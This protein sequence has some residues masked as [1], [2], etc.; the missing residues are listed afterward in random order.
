MPG[1]RCR[2]GWDWRVTAFAH[3]Y[4]QDVVH[5]CN[6]CLEGDDGP[7]T[8]DLTH[9]YVPAARS[10]QLGYIYLALQIFSSG[11]FLYDADLAART[12]RM[13]HDKRKCVPLLR[14]RHGAR[15]IS[16]HV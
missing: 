15:L 1:G 10:S 14:G 12:P 6:N 11:A 9:G 7:Y 13:S 3:A 2:F 4:A 16:R 8:W 5:V